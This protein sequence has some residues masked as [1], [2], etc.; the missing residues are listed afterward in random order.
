MS[1]LE[2]RVYELEN[3]LNEL[4]KVVVKKRKRNIAPPQ[5]LPIPIQNYPYPYYY[6][7]VYNPFN[8]IP[9]Q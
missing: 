7:Y 6:P 1:D 5:S 4:E 2:K 8:H 9:N 3:R